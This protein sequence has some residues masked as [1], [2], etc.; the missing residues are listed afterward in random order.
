M[1][2]QDDKVKVKLDINYHPFLSYRILPDATEYY[3]ML[4]DATGCYRMR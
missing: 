1:P 2:N 4:P 3:R